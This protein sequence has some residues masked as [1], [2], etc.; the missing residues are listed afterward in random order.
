MR[1]FDH[2]HIIRSSVYATVGRSSVRPYFPSGRRTTAARLLLCSID[3]CTAG[4]GR[5]SAAAVSLAR[6]EQMWT[7]PRCQRT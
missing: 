5:R 7:V 6:G 2:P 3:C 4:M 1:L